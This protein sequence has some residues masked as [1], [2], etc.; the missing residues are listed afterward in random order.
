MTSMKFKRLWISLS[1]IF[2]LIMLNSGSIYAQDSWK[3][4]FDDICS[5][6]GIAITFTKEELKALVDRCDKLKPTI[7]TLDESQKK[8][9]LKR[10]KMCR[11]MFI[12][13]I[14]SKKE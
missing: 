3:A 6:T 9:Y 4:E 7:E 1:L 2:V 14:E 10:L 5:K 11:D 13:A 12:F 8:V